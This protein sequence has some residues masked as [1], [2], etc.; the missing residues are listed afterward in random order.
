MKSKEIFTTES[1]EQITLV[2]FARLHKQLRSIFSV[3]NGAHLKGNLKQR[4]TQMSLLKAEGLMPGASDLI[5]PEPIMTRPLH[6]GECHGLYLE[7]KRT[8]KSTTSDHQ[9]DFGCMVAE[10]G[11]EFRIAHGINEGI[12]I[13]EDYIY[14][15]GQAKKIRNG[16]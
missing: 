9:I 3:P 8:G 16:L 12:D 2:E 4:A 10:R 7:M 13:L 1:K 5:L 14:R 6:P 15:L 11:Y